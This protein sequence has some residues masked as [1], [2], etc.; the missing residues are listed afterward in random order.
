MLH[1]RAKHSSRRGIANKRVTTR[2]QNDVHGVLG[3]RRK[4]FD[5]AIERSLVGTDEVNLVNCGRC[6]VVDREYGPARARRLPAWSTGRARHRYQRRRG[7]SGG[8]ASGLGL[9]QA[10]RGEP[11]ATRSEHGRY[12]YR[13][14]RLPG[15]W[16]PSARR[17]RPGDRL[18]S[19]HCLRSEFTCEPCETSTRPTRASLRHG[20]A[21]ERP[22][23]LG[24]T[25]VATGEP[26]PG[27]NTL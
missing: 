26:P 21:A 1:R 14:D 3:A 16:T 12:C 11:H 13:D 17:R 24:C 10:R 20:R 22:T 8:L 9:G 27:C 19:C 5:F 25:R 23:C 7:A 2:T 6:K 4:H 15:P 18:M